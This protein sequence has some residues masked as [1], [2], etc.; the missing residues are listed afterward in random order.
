MIGVAGK[1]CH[2]PVAVARPASGGPIWCGHVSAPKAMRSLAAFEDGLAVA[3]GAADGED[4]VG[5]A[6]IAPLGQTG[7]E[8]SAVECSCRL[9]RARPGSPAPAARQ[10]TPRPPGPCARPPSRRGSRRISRTAKDKPSRR[11]PGR[12]GRD[13]V[14]R[15]RVRGRPSCRPIAAMVICMPAPRAWAAARKAAGLQSGPLRPVL[16]PPDDRPA[17]SF[18][19]CRRRELPAGRHGR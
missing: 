17:T 5:D 1:D 14:A 9:R 16:A 2:G 18:P 8:G 4:E 7:G 6:A 13:S 11:R 10:A 15:G 12:L 3:V 19:D